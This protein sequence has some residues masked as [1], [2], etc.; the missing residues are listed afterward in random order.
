MTS[1]RYGAPISSRRINSPLSPT[2]RPSPDA[3]RLALYIL[4]GTGI[5]LRLFHFI[6][7]RSLWIDEVYVALSLIRMDFGRLAQPA[8]LYE[9][10]APILFLWLCRGAVRLFGEQEQALRL[11]PLLSG[12]AALLLF[13]PVAR[14]LLRP[15]GAAVAVGALALAPPLIYHTVEIKQYSAELLATVVALWLFLRYRSRSD[16]PAL[17]QWSLAGA[18]LIWF[19]YAVIFVLMGIAGATSLLYLLRRRWQ[20]FFRHLLPFGL[21]AVSFGAYYLLFTSRYTESGWLVYW[22]RTLRAFMPLP[23]TS[24]A[25]LKWPFYQLYIALDYP[26][27]LLLDI[28]TWGSTLPRLLLRA[29][30]LACGVVGAWSFFKKD[31]AVFSLLLF[32]VLLTMLAS[33]MEKY[34]FY[35]RLLV[36]LAP[37]FILFIASGCDY[38]SQR[39]SAGQWAGYVLPGLLLLPPL[40]ASARQVADPDLFGGYKKSYFREGFQHINADYRLGDVVYLYWDMIPPYLYYKQAYP[41]KFKAVEGQDYRDTAHSM[42]DYVNKTA[43]DFTTA[44]GPHRGWLICDDLFKGKIG[45]YTG[46]PAWYYQESDIS[47][48]RKLHR[49]ISAKTGQQHQDIFWRRTVHACLFAAPVR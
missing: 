6:H 7:N 10:K 43:T 14:A 22:F 32:A 12:L 31:R 30:P 5:F 41:L 16:W 3:W 33:G 49:R 11:V 26:L 24:L 36:F 47:L 48:F 44:V 13:V 19:S 9:Q 34:P 1:P 25:D 46:R 39:L 18:V 35:E 27:G 40:L 37:V 42:T 8:L 38:L 45:D 17:V 15:L 4:L 20:P 29:V 28:K 2:Q 21:W 23:P